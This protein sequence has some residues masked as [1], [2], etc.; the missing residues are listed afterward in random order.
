MSSEGSGGCEGPLCKWTNVMRGWAWRWFVLSDNT[1]TYYTS[2][3]KRLQGD[4]RGQLKLNGAFLSIEED[5]NFSITVEDHTYH[6]QVLLLFYQLRG[7]V[8]VRFDPD[9]K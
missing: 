2:K 4:K 7:L 1:L 5:T 3:E 6:F 9:A 8:P